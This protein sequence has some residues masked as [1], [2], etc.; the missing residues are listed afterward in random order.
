M[1]IINDVVYNKNSSGTIDLNNNINDG[2]TISADGQPVLLKSNN[3][4]ALS[5]TDDSTYQSVASLYTLGGPGIEL[6]SQFLGST[7][8]KILILA[9]G[10]TLIETADGLGLT[11]SLNITSTENIFK[12]ES[13][14][15]IAKLRILD[16][17][18]FGGNPAILLDNARTTGLYSRLDMTTKITWTAGN[19]MSKSESVLDVNNIFFQT[20]V[21]EAENARL[22]LGKAYDGI[23]SAALYSFGPTNTTRIISTYSTIQLDANYNVGSLA[24]NNIT[25]LQLKGTYSSSDTT[26]YIKT[27]NKA[28]FTCTDS[29]DPFNMNPGETNAYIKLDRT[30]NVTA[31]FGV[32]DAVPANTKYSNISFIADNATIAVADGNSVIPSSVFV[33]K[34]VITLTTPNTLYNAQQSGDLELRADGDLRLYSDYQGNQNNINMTVNAIE[35][36]AAGGSIKLMSNGGSS[37]PAYADDA[38]AVGGGLTTGMLYQTDGTGAAPLDV[39]GI[40]MIVQ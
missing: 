39:A 40:V 18:I 5:N 3:E 30:S 37:L 36:N 14:Y 7:Y 23:S 15:N 12:I 20:L 26:A 16:S 6:N 8:S 1:K 13:P 38:A 2:I 25:L 21:D 31:E 10:S 34:D 19:T 9:T 33:N 29:Q 24:T 17:G 22:D 32:V 4:V 27:D 35:L 28:Y 11:S